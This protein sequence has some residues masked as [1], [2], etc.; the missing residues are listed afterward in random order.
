LARALS[1]RADAD[2]ATLVYEASDPKLAAD[3]NAVKAVR[4]KDGFALYFSR[5]PIPYDR[6]AKE[7]AYLPQA[8]WHHMGIYA[9][10]RERLQAFVRLGPS[11]LEQTEKLEQLRALENGWR[12]HLA[13]AQTYSSGIDTP[14]DL[15]AARELIRAGK[16]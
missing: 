5:A 2:L 8:F 12:I 14:A 4:D 6:S 10:R 3:P 16:A 15:E 13:V 11:R 9:Y 1:E 7:R